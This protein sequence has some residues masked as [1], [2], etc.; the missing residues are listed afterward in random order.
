M[1]P[2][3]VRL[4]E[5]FLL[6]DFIGN[7]SVYSKGLV[8]AVDPEDR[9]LPLKIGNGT[10]LCEALL[11]PI[12]QAHGPLSIAYGIIAPAV[13]SAIV[14]YQDPTKPSHHLWNLGAA[15]DVLVHGWVN[16]EPEVDDYSNSPIGLIFDLHERGLPYS[17]AISYSES[18]YVCLAASKREI[19][20]TDPRLACYEN[21]YEGARGR[22]PDYRKYA[23]EVSKK[24]AQLGG[25]L[26]RGWRG[27]GFPTYHGGGRQQYQH[28]RVSKYTML[29]DWL[30]DLN[31]ISIGR[32]NVPNR[33]HEPLMDL[34]EACGDV[35]DHLID[36]LAVPRLNI[37]QGYVAPSNHHHAIGSAWSLK[38]AS[39]ALAYPERLDSG[40][41]DDVLWHMSWMP[42]WKARRLKVEAI[43]K[44]DRITVS[45]QH[46]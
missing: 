45:I 15:A 7:H 5:H 16:S 14:A 6:S 26:P 29:I 9:E 20:A 34:F 12:L 21:R 32:P 10:T 22:K 11:E 40:R 37:V 18:P 38:R 31:L 1:D 36:T 4:S 17:R 30:F 28:L 33:R 3:E 35:Y 19:Q 39:F 8:N 23:S 44:N 13:S 27:H 24:N 46:D 42:A 41:I 43:R 25:V 2:R